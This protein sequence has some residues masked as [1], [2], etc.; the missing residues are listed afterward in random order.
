MAREAE[1]KTRVIF[2]WLKE[3]EVSKRGNGKTVSNISKEPSKIQT[4]ERS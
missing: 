4:S 2:L 1:K 3:K